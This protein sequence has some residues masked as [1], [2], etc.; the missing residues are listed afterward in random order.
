MIL[1]STALLRAALVAFVFLPNLALA[2][3]DQFPPTAVIEVQLLDVTRADAPAEV[4]HTV[5]LSPQRQPPFLFT[6]RYDPRKIDAA[7]AYALKATIT[8]G[9]EL[10][11]L[12]TNNTRVLTQGNPSHR[13]LVLEMAPG[14]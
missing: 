3:A 1:S 10:R 14:K 8:V 12:S 4:L 7:H 5:T 13:D 2:L 9:G 6:I 11:F